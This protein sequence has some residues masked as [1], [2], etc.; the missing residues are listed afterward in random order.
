MVL[1]LLQILI[2]I[3]TRERMIKIVFLCEG[4]ICR[5]PTAE[6]IFKD[7]VKKEEISDK[8]DISSFALIT[9]TEGQHIY[10]KSVEQL[11]LHNIP[12]DKDRVAHP[13]TRSIF[14]SA[15]Y[16]VYMEN[17]HKIL[18]KRRLFNCN[19]DKTCRLLDFTEDKRDLVDPY[20]SRD[21]ITAYNDLYNGCVAMLEKVKE[22]L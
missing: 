21:F 1:N 15:D 19:L 9:S 7:F 2:I 5:S 8:F 11:D 10:R 22:K 3:I 20:F 17:Y 4:N 13:I 18:L 12:Y 16:V 6:F 14:D